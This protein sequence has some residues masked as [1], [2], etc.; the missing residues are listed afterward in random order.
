MRDNK[1]K[2]MM[3]MRVG[4]VEQLV[5][6]GTEVACYARSTSKKQ[7]AKQI[8]RLKNYC[9]KKGYDVKMTVSEKCKGR[10]FFRFKLNYL[11]RKRMPEVIVM[12]DVS[13]LSR[14]VLTANK[15]INKIRSR[16]KVLVFAEIDEIVL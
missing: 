2:A 13:R 4:N 8:E 6:K 9:E 11:I 15:Y 3:Y 14:N 16:G 12:D 5:V 10:N 7:M 1:V